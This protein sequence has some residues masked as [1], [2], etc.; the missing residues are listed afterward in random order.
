VPAVAPLF[1]GVAAG[2]AVQVLAFAVEVAL[3]VTNPPDGPVDTAY[4]FRLAVSGSLGVAV[5][6][7]A[8]VRVAAW[9]CR[10]RG[11][12]GPVAGRTAIGAGLLAGLLVVGTG[13]TVGSGWL[14]LPVYLLGVLLGTAAAALWG[15]RRGDDAL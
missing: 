1:A 6:C 14:T 8:A 10:L 2:V 7:I 5:A 11:V 13:V 9:R 12:G 15:R 4:R 3:V